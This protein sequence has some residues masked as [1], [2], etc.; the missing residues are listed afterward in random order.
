MYLIA[1]KIKEFDILI[2]KVFLFI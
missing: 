1:A 2:F